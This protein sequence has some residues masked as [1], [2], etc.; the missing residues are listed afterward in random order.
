MQNLSY[1]EVSKSAILHNFTQFRKFIHPETKIISVLKANAYGHGITQVAPIIE[2]QTDYFAVDDIEELRTLRQVTQKPTLILGYILKDQLEEALTLNADIV[3]YDI[4]RAVLLDQIA[5]KHNTKARIHIK[6]DAALGRQGV[7][8]SELEQFTNQLAQLKNLEVVA[9]YAHFANIEDIGDPTEGASEFS[10]ARKQIE[11]F[12]N[13]V[14][15]VVKKQFPQ[16]FTH[17]SSTAG[18]IVYEKKHHHSDFIRLGLGLYGL[19]PSQNIQRVL[20]PQGF[21]LKPAL[22]WVSHIAQIKELPANSTIGYG[23]TCTTYKSTKIAIIPQGYSDGYDRGLSNS[24]KVLIQGTHCVILGRVMMNMIIA[25]VS[26]LEDV[27]PEDEVI[28]LGSQGHEDITAEEFAEKA[29]TI[30]YE[31]VARINPLL[32]RVLTS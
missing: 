17:I 31:V 20:Q 23:L 7:L 28:L 5:G 4:E 19:W 25:D 11:I 15:N 24:G 26:E 32:P 12:K 27:H 10:H 18:T 30:N 13:A 9:A 8:P 14:E 2:T 6:I 21:T 22:R 3:I 16:A 29:G 1:I